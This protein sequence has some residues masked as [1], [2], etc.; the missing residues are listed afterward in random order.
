M[1]RTRAETFG[2][3]EDRVI[4]KPNE[5]L[6]GVQSYA[7]VDELVRRGFKTEI[8]RHKSHRTRLVLVTPCDYDPQDTGKT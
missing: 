2:D 3:R 4:G 7:L 6:A 1:R 8:R 5:G